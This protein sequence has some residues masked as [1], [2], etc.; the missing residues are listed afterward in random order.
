MKNTFA[1]DKDKNIVYIADA[2]KGNDYFCPSCRKKF[3]F[4]NSG[5]EGRGSRCPHFAHPAHSECHESELHAIFKQKTVE[6]LK[7]F[8]DIHNFPVVIDN[9]RANLLGGVSRIEGE[10]SLGVGNP[11]PDIARVDYGGDCIVA[12]EIVVNHKPENVTIEY[13]DKNDIVCL[14]YDVKAEDIKDVQSIANKL[15]K[16][17]KFFIPSIPKNCRRSPYRNAPAVSVYKGKLYKK[18]NRPFD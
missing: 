1:Y 17:D 7:N 8:L 2:K 6:I 16:P 11:R 12:L 5:K 4:K 18:K 14:Q 9:K 13:Y 15:Q 10:F 3:V